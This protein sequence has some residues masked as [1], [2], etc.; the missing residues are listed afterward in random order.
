[1]ASGRGRRDHS[2]GL[3][4][5]RELPR[6]GRRRDPLPTPPH[7]RHT[8]TASAYLGFTTGFD[9]EHLRN[10]AA[11][12]ALPLYA[13]RIEDLGQ[14]DFVKVD[15]PLPSRRAADAGGAAEGR[16]EPG[17]QRFSTSKGGSG[18]AGAGGEGR[19]VFRLCGGGRGVSGARNW[20]PARR[21]NSTGATQSEPR[22]FV[23]VVTGENR[24]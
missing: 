20:R 23:S 11:P 14:G 12:D 21:R 18:A 9:G 19:A 22:N 24:L 4:Y 16:A 10:I 6:S 7:S 15:S 3:A 2:I 5:R 1:V 8:A 13:A 17:G